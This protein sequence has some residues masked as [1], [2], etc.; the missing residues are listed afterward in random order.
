MQIGVVGLGRMG[1]NISRRLMKHGHQCVVFDQNPAPGKALAGEGATVAN[2]LKDM[3]AKLSKPRVVWLMLPQ[4]PITQ[5]AVDT[6]AGLLE[7]G[8]HHHRRRQCLL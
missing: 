4:G 5:G 3:A 2:D 6:L 8:R 7:S 1:G